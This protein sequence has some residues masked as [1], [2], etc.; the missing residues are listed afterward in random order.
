MYLPH[1]HCQY[2]T[3]DH[4]LPHK[5]PHSPA[6]LSITAAQPNNHSSK[7]LH[8]P[9]TSTMLRCQLLLLAAACLLATA[10]AQGRNCTVGSGYDATSNLCYKCYAGTFSAGGVNATCSPCANNTVSLTGAGACIPCPAGMRDN[11]RKVCGEWL[12]AVG[13]TSAIACTAWAPHT[14]IAAHHCTH[15]S[16]TMPAATPTYL[17]QCA[18]PASSPPT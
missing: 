5:L 7:P 4:K 2:S 11:S 3:I 17:L 15:A 1:R 14:G 12:S 6:L 13:R 18:S 8:S 9:H 10:S 16:L